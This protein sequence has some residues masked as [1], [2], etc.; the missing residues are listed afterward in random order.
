M[1]SRVAARRRSRNDQRRPR[2]AASGLPAWSKS[3]R[4]DTVPPVR[5]PRNSSS[6]ASVRDCVIGTLA[7]AAGI[8]CRLPGRSGR[9]ARPRSPMRNDAATAAATVPQRRRMNAAPWRVGCVG[10][11]HDHAARAPILIDTLQDPRA[12]AR[13]TVGGEGLSASAVRPSRY[14]RAFR[15]GTR[16]DW[17]VS[18]TCSG[19]D[20]TMKFRRR[21]PA[22]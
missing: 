17:Q 12:L 15:S 6:D 8:D 2:R 7:C 1:P 22:R 16:R 18:Q 3:G 5:C 9:D 20:P 10:R 19:R 4:P 21:N 14:P 11:E 13:K